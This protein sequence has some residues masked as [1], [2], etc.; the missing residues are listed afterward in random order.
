MA[1]PDASRLYELAEDVARGE[2]II[3]IAK[4]FRLE[5]ART[6]QDFAEHQHPNG[7]VLLV[8]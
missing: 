8:A 5:E 3:P 6:A 4:V 1:Q 7:K 2:F